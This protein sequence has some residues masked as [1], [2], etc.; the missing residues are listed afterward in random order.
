MEPSEVR[1]RI[2]SGELSLAK[3]D[4]KSEVWNNFKLVL[5]SEKTCIGF[6]ECIKCSALL[7]YDSKKTGTSS[8][9]R[10]MK[11]AC[12]HRKDERQPSMSSFTTTTKNIPLRAKQGV[13]EKCVE[14]LFM[15]VPDLGNFIEQTLPKIMEELDAHLRSS[16]YLASNDAPTIADLMIL[17]E[18]DQ[19]YFDALIDMASSVMIKYVHVKR[20]LNDM[21]KIKTYDANAKKAMANF[22]ELLCQKNVPFKLYGFLPSQP[23]RSVL[24]LAN[25]AKLN[26]T[27]NPISPQNLKSPEYLS[28]NPEGLVPTIVQG[29]TTL[30]EGAAILIHLCEIN[31]LT[32]WYP[33]DLQKKTK[34]NKWLH[35]HH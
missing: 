24:L 33:S 31:Q 13:T 4:G 30:S 2:T 22:K 14:S 8:L 29:T 17:P 27:F 10:H 26:F 16:K 20:W 35:W 6:V 18:I 32:K 19:L 15:H 21:Q 1:K 9:N 11:K 7:A 28:I 3:S 34:V 23:T 25:A 5:D 12:Q